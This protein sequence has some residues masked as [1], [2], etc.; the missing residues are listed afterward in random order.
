MDSRNNEQ[1]QTAASTVTSAVKTGKAIANIAK[2]A[3]RGGMPGAALA[4]AWSSRKWLLPVLALAL[5][6][7][8][9]VAMLP[10]IIFGTPLTTDPESTAPSGLI[11]D[12]VLTQTMMD[13]NDRI[14]AALSDG[15]E[16]ILYRIN[17]DFLSSGCDEKEVNNPYGSDVRSY[18]MQYQ[19]YLAH[20]SVA[21]EQSY[22]IADPSKG[23][24]TADAVITS[25]YLDRITDVNG[26]FTIDDL[27]PG[28]YSVME[29]DAPTGYVLNKTEFHVEL[30]PGKDSQL[31]VSNEKKPDLKIIKNE[32]AN[33]F[34][35]NYEAIDVFASWTQDADRVYTKQSAFSAM[36]EDYEPSIR[37]IDFPDVKKH[38]GPSRTKQT[39]SSSF[40]RSPYIAQY[41][42]RRANGFCQL[43][44]NP[45]P[46]VAANGEPY[47]ESHHV[48]WL[49]QGGQD[50]IENT[51][52]LC[53]NCHRKMH[54]INDQADVAKLKR[55][56]G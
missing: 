2:G 50:S 43:C 24:L 19:I 46:F 33:A 34:T 51:V 17:E 45:A 27:E 39:T 53:P 15:L 48:I 44:D 32:S 30:F 18:V 23:T 55:I 49:S 20:N 26:S 35:S 54:I 16:D 29:M 3:A 41:A 12:E 42:K 31:I 5:I 21:T 14:S 7:I 47:L 8:I 37:V 13:L 1:K 56:C 38:S 6:P 52:A 22:I 9:I 11:S 25:H 36:W 10:S 40:S 4:A 28:V